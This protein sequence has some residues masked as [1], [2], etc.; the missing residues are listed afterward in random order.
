MCANWPSERTLREESNHLVY[1]AVSCERQG[2]KKAQSNFSVSLVQTTFPQFSK[3]ETK[4]CCSAHIFTTG[5]QSSHEE[6]M[7]LENWVLTFKAATHGMLLKAQRRDF[8]RLKVIE[9]RTFCGN[10]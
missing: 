8:L 3:L 4:P 5:R 7:R 9:Q 2:A 6:Q 1:Y 10:V